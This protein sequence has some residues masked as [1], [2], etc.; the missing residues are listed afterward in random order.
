MR[1]RVWV[2]VAGADGGAADT[3]RAEQSRAP[4][5]APPRT[6]ST[7]DTDEL[8]PALDADWLGNYADFLLCEADAQVQ[9]WKFAGSTGILGALGR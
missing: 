4:G 9:L 3:G 8:G 1:P 5:G 6:S 7:G 2:P